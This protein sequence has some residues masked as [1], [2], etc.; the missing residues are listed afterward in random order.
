MGVVTALHLN[1]VE[2]PRPSIQAKEIKATEV[3]RFDAARLATE[4]PCGFNYPARQVRLPGVAAHLPQPAPG[5]VGTI[6]VVR[7]LLLNVLATL[8]LM[9]CLCGIVV[10]GRSYEVGH[11]VHVAWGPRSVW[12]VSEGGS[13]AVAM[14]LRPERHGVRCTWGSYAKRAGAAA[15]LHGLWHFGR[16]PEVGAFDVVVPQWVVPAV[17]A[18]L[19]AARIARWRRLRRRPATTTCGGC[20]YDLTGNV[21]GVCPECGSVR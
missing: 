14:M 7:G 20:G 12:V 17:F 1:A 21:S 13:F 6:V 3:R 8:S 9:V 10:W 5:A 15:A 18:P 19:P 4:R 2:R 16:A 11:Q